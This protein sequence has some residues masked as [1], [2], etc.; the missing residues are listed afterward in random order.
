MKNKERYSYILFS[1][2]FI[3]PIFRSGIPVQEE[4]QLYRKQGL[5]FQRQGRLDEAMACYRKAI[6]L[7]PNFVI[8]TMTR[9]LFMKQ[10]ELDKAEEVYLSAL[11]IDPNYPNLYS[12]REG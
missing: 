11:G 5:Q 3:L 4:V 9:G 8:A 10:G 7:D 2:Y 1:L 6:A 12:N